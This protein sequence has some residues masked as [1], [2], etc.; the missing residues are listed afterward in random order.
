MSDWEGE[1]P[2]PVLGVESE[3]EPDVGVAMLDD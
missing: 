2:G 1:V 3:A